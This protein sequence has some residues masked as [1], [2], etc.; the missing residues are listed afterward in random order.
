[1]ARGFLTKILL[2]ALALASILWIRPCTA[3]SAEI[4]RSIEIQN[5]LASR[6]P[7]V[8]AIIRMKVG[9]P[10]DRDKMENSIYDLRKWGVFKNVEVI[11]KHEGNDVSLIYQLEDAYLIKD[12]EIHGNYPL[13]EKRV[14]RAIF[15]SLGDVY[16]PE[17][18]P[19]QIERLIEFYEK[20][21]RKDTSV[22]IE[23][24]KDEQNRMVTL[25]ISI[26]KGRSFRVGEVTIR[27]NTIFKDSRIENKI[28]RFFDFKPNR[29]KKDLEKIEKLYRDHDYPRARVK[30]A[31][32]HFNEEKRRVDVTID[33]REGKKIDIRFVGND[34]QF[35][36]RLKKVV[37]VSD[38]GETDEFELDYS[39]N[40]LV[41][42]Y[43]N[44]GYEDVKVS[45]EKKEISKE[46]IEVTFT[47]D[48]GPLRV[49]KAIDFEGNEHYSDRTLRNQMITKEQ[50]I[51][52]RGAFIK[53][54][55][56]R[57][58]E[59]IASF[60]QQN[61]FLDA[62]IKDWK[63]DLIATKDKYL[64]DID[65]SE[66]KR[67]TVESVTFDGL[68]QFKPEQIKDFLIVKEKKPYSASRLEED[69]RAILVFY[70]NHGFTY[71]DVKTEIE[72]VAP[73]K[74]AI[75][76]KI[77]EGPPVKVGRI[78]FVGNV[79]TKRKTI[80]DALRFKEGGPFTPQEVLES[81]TTL[82]KLGIFDAITLETL[83][84][85]GKE[86][87]IHV[88]IRVEEKK[89]KLVD[90]GLSYDTDTSFKA[91]LVYTRLNLFGWGKR[92]DLKL[93]GGL[94]Y[95]R[96]EFD[97]VDPR[98][99][100]SDWQFQT[101]A[102]AQLEK[103]TF[104][105]DSQMGGSIGFLRDLTRRLSLLL[106]YEFTRTD[107]NESK[108]DFSLLPAGTA[109]NT[110]GKFT[111]SAIYDRR[112]NYGDPRSGFYAA[113][114][115][116][117]GTRF[118]GFGGRANFIKLGARFGHWYSPFRR[119]TIA[120]ALRVD[121]IYQLTGS[122]IPTQE[123]IFLGGDDTVRGFKQD[124]LNPSGG[125]I[126]FVHNL[127]LQL[128]MFKGFEAVTFLDSGSLTNSI[129]EISLNSIRHS[130]GF[131]LRYVTPVGPIRLDYGIILD[132]R[133]GEN[134]GRLH[135]TFGYFF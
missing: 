15:F 45:V 5:Q 97:Y 123:L 21:G 54:V 91:K 14:R 66:G 37:S 128:R 65:V 25:V 130:A 92:I 85:K 105:E 72:E 63:R 59:T 121:N 70:S 90:L 31:E 57:D 82:R 26:H 127:E 22:F 134:F 17:K 8:L 30:L 29:I 39:K 115:T 49:I 69:A 10:F 129:A 106:R 93:T 7:D 19:E 125:K 112:D 87:T 102:F 76:Y 52:K 89:D 111:F 44:L 12:I 75:H 13:L 110:T 61:G 1:M 116:N 114:I 6:R 9:E 34:H 101:T 99:F 100:G 3:F 51:G 81:Q 108:T 131:G 36:S 118:A 103:R 32:V 56:E 48:E 16:N 60:Y 53:A 95:D 78:L 122:S 133:T 47:I 38:T 80:L 84:L 62:K 120:N 2:G 24:H 27:G 98:L 20:E 4:L 40:Q 46:E 41:A 23:E 58:L 88:V 86:E 35:S 73:D 117:Y 124:A 18:I 33:I 113:G 132:R 107:F 74:V 119:F 104:F 83:G 109:D 126:G 42:H 11:V 77:Q 50:S 68:K 64:I 79:V 55:F 96:G 43:Q 28:S 135:F 94:K 67:T 71:A